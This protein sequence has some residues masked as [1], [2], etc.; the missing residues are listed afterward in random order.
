ML[1][2][3][4]QLFKVSIENARTMC[5][6][7]SEL[8]I[9]APNPSQWYRSDVLIIK[10]EQNF[11]HLSGISIADSEQVNTGWERPINL[12]LNFLQ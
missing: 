10:F 5:E 6:I 1:Q 2:P 3:S 12:F 4:G 11:T 7:Y 9:T 8:T